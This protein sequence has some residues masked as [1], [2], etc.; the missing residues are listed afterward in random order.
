MGWD[1]FIGIDYSGAETPEARLKGLQV[2]TARPSREPE[3]VPPPDPEGHVYR[4]WSRQAIAHW[5]RDQLQSDQRL[6]IGIDHGFSFPET[7]FQRYR[8]SDWNAFLADFVRHWPTHEAGC[9][10][11][12]ILDGVWWENGQK[13]HGERTGTA[14]ELRLCEK[15]TSSA[16]SVFR[17]QG[18]GCVGKSTHA[19]LPWL[20]FLREEC[21][22]RLY[23]WP[24]DGWIPEE[25]KSVIAETY[26][27]IF[28]RRYPKANRTADQQDAYAIARWLEETARRGAMERY[29]QVPRTLP[30]RKTAA[31]EGWILGVA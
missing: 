26:P 22:N 21:G 16:T 13:P 6:L 5:L 14:D 20:K 7:Y 23:F 8:L 3:A 12:C 2:Y 17:M 4:N 25:G 27:S 30:E 9:C 31:L 28:R 11:D 10:I 19:G 24:F 18:Q 1:L 29:F 15:W